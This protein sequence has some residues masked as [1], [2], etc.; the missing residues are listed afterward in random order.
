MQV[1]LTSTLVGSKDSEL[2]TLTSTTQAIE[3][4]LLE[5]TMEC[6]QKLKEI[7]ALQVPKP[8]KPITPEYHPP[9]LLPGNLSIR[10]CPLAPSPPRFLPPDLLTFAAPAS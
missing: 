3:R 5:K 6:E 10:P 2:S 8:R 9:G 4:A 1:A 7:D